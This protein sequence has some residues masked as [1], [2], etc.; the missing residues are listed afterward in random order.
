VELKAYDKAYFIG[1]GGIGMSALARWFASRG[2]RVA[3]YDRTPTMLT[4]ELEREG[5][6]IHYEDNPALIDETFL[7]DPARTLVVYTP[8]IPADARELAYFRSNGQEVLKRSRVLGMITEDLTSVAVAGTHGKTTTSA[9]VAHLLHAAQVPCLAFVGG[10]TRNYAS[11]L[12]LPEVGEEEEGNGTVAVVEADEYDRSFLQLRP[13]IAVFTSLDPDHLDIYGSPEEMVAGYRQFAA[14]LKPG[15]Y[16]VVQHSLVEQ[17]LPDGAAA[18]TL[19]TY[20]IE[21]GQARAERVRADGDIF[22]FDLVTEDFSL[23]GVRLHM[24]GFHNVENAV[25]AAAA[26]SRLGLE[27]EQIRQ[28]LESFMGV[29]RRFEFH[30][31]PAGRVLVDD[32]AHHPTEIEA[33]LRSLH[34]LYPGRRLTVCFQPHLFSRTRDFAEGFGQALSLADTLILLDIYPARELPI[35]GVTA[36]TIGKHV[37]GPQILRS[38]LENLPNTLAQLPGLDVVAT[39]GAGDIYTA[40]PQIAKILAAQAAS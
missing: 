16:R 36:D 8:A 33:F 13:D 39:V 11:N 29:Q 35:P 4:A 26:C 9:M 6:S 14:Q 37:Q 5:I 34:G 12:I 30:E 19:I 17:L 22:V 21:A 7:R 38:S 40:I 18:D 28:G 3:G 25:A 20:G 10:I 23:P 2:W 32:Y 1:I 15:G 27:P 31:A 24:P